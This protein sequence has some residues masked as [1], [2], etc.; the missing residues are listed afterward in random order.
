MGHGVDIMG[1]VSHY[2]SVSHFLADKRSKMGHFC[3]ILDRLT[4]VSHFPS[5]CPLFGG[6]KRDKVGQKWT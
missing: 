4:K 1:H 6:T 3:P 2:A 5:F